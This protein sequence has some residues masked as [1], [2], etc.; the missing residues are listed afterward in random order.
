MTADSRSGRHHI[1]SIA[2]HF[3]GNDTP[4]TDAFVR[5]LVV[6]LTAD[7]FSARVGAALHALWTR[8]EG[9]GSLFPSRFGRECAVRESPVALR[10]IATFLH[11]VSEPPPESGL[12][13]GH[14][15]LLR[16]GFLANREDSLTAGEPGVLG[17]TRWPDLVAASVGLPGRRDAVR[18]GRLMRL[19]RVRRL[20]LV[21]ASGPGN[22]PNPQPSLVSGIAG[23]Y[24]TVA[25]ALGSAFRLVRCEF[26]EPGGVRGDLHAALVT[27]LQD[28][29][30][31]E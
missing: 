13:L 28:A 8:E 9:R 20:T 22:P 25:S 23:V 21:A 14:L 18:L 5:V 27:I 3:L 15:G 10:S 12:E 1:G 11:P 19:V 29:L 30:A 16:D 4:G 26:P 24:G 2:H 17:W 31:P 6:G 7:S